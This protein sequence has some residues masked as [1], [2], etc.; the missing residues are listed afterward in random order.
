MSLTSV[1][2]NGCILFVFC[3]RRRRLS[4]A[5]VFLVNLGIAD[6]LLSIAS[7]PL[8]MISSFKHRWDFEELGCTLYAFVCYFLGLASIF[9][10]TGIALIRYMKTCTPVKGTCYE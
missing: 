7:Y 10:I 5:E 6:I 8:T 2:G 3:F 4:P 1:V 9:S